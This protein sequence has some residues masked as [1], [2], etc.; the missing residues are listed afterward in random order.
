MDM[1]RRSGLFLGT[2]LIL[3]ILTVTASGQFIDAVRV[4][5]N[6]MGQDEWV[7]QIV[8]SPTGKEIISAGVD[9]RVVMWNAETGKTGWE[10]KLPSMVL[11]LSLSPDGRL[12]AAGDASGT[13]SLIDAASGKVGNTWAA[14]KKIVNATAWSQDGKYLATGGD[15]GIVRVW[16]ADGQKAI[17]EINPA[18]GNILS[19]NF[20]D[21]QIAIGLLDT[22]TKT[23]RRRT[24]GLENK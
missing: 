22:Q 23:R 24:L 16:P 1:L 19:L 9:G 10:T 13:V 11:T 5:A 2:Q 17:A 14:D 4:N 15:E 7:T 12:L 8:A 21:S 18:H 3:F 6:A 20:K